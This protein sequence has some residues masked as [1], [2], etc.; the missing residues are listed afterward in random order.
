MMVETLAL[1]GGQA[2][3]AAADIAPCG[4]VELF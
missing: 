4:S 1:Q 3:L 2:R